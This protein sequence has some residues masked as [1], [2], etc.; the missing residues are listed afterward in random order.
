MP[1]EPL[2]IFFSYSRKD[3]DLMQDLVGHL[4][5]LRRSQLIHSWHDGCIGPGE[6]W[7]P[8]I[9]EN[10]EKAQIILLLV[11]VDFINS[12]YCYTVELSRAIARHKAGT[13]CVIPVILRSCLWKHVPVGDMH[14]GDLQALPKDAKPIREWAY[15]DAAYTSIAEGLYDKIQQLRQEQVQADYAAN[16]AHYGQI[17]ADAVQAG[18]P[19]SQAA[20]GK[21]KALQQQLGLQDDD[22]DPIERPIR[23]PA[24]ARH[25]EALATAERQRQTQAETEYKQREQ[26]ETEQKRRAAEAEQQRQAAEHYKSGRYHLSQDNYDKAIA[27]FFR[28]DQMGHPRAA[29]KLAET[30]KL[31]LRSEAE[32]QIQF[33]VKKFKELINPSQ[34]FGA[35]KEDLRL[36]DD[37][38][39][40][41]GID[42]T[43]LRDL[44]KAQDW[45][46][47]DR[48]TYE[49]MIRAVGKKSGDWFTE[50]ELLNFPCADL[51][52][53]DRL[54]VNYS[55]GKFGFS[56]QKQ[57]YVETG[58]PL[59]S[60]YHKETWE[61]FCDRVGWRKAGNYLNY[62]DLKANPSL[63]PTGEFPC[64][65]LLFIVS[66][67]GVVA[68]CVSLFSRAE[69]CKL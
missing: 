57:I 41:K 11:S 34:S 56:V 52:T 3:Q 49:V 5:P 9:K 17:F 51:L 14:L 21:L 60:Q 37:L 7:E 16:L 53:I 1:S 24:E 10:L 48:E 63:S 13:A 42:Y 58:N 38:S 4:E 30:H 20:L 44:L 64:G 29:Q 55:Q 2:P 12:D 66:W 46:A 40:E 47:A 59:D 26:E 45:R 62:S 31:K 33:V 61:A 54:W 25:R 35:E 50:D 67:G 27:D 19:L 18:Y 23:E 43:R 22:I 65:W 8:Q 69:T 36:E 28:A 68:L 6:E 15:L 32:G 39:S